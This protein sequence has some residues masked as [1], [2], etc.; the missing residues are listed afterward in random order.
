MFLVLC[1]PIS[2]SLHASYPPNDCPFRHNKVRFP[3]CHEKDHRR[4]SGGGAAYGA[5][6]PPHFSEIIRQILFMRVP[7][8]TCAPLFLTASYVFAWYSC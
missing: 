2:C 5:R 7:L 3:A 1:T 6:A 8:N 4:R